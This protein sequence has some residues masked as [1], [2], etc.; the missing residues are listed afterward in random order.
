VLSLID[1][2]FAFRHARGALT[3]RRRIICGGQLGGALD[4]SGEGDPE[5]NPAR[6]RY[7]LAGANVVVNVARVAGA[8]NST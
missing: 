3:R 6:D 4:L 5:S 2:D 1:A 7:F 8:F